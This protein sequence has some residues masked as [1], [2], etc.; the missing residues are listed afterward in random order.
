MSNRTAS[1]FLIHAKEGQVAYTAL[2]FPKSALCQ[3]PGPLDYDVTDK[4]L[5]VG[6][7]LAVMV[8]DRNMEVVDL[9]VAD[10]CRH[11]RLAQEHRIW[12]ALTTDKEPTPIRASNARS[13]VISEMVNAGKFNY[14]LNAQTLEH[15]RKADPDFGK[16]LDDKGTICH[17]APADQI[18]QSDISEALLMRDF[19]QAE[20]KRETGDGSDQFT[21]SHH[22]ALEIQ[23]LRNTVLYR[24]K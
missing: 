11:L 14:L 17:C 13:L 10:A 16:F 2:D 8:K 24:I 7:V 1:R 21:F 15:I 18:L 5:P 12:E 20:L 3:L 9:Q 6:S 19:K 23:T 4:G 22:W